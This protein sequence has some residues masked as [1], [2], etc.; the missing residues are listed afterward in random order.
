MS[1]RRDGL[2]RA[3]NTKNDE[4]YTR[5]QDIAAEC[6]HYLDQFQRK[7]IYCN[8]DTTDSNFVRYFMQL[9][10]Q[11]I[12]KDVLWSGG[13]GGL[14][15]RSPSA[16]DLLQTADIVVTNPPFSLFREY[17][18]LL[19]ASGKQ[20]LI[21]GNQN[22][23]SYKDFFPLF[24]AKQVRLGYKA[25]SPMLFDVPEVDPA[26]SYKIVDGRPMASIGVAWF[27]NLPV[28]SKHGVRLHNFYCGNEAL[29]PKYDNYDAINV[30]RVSDIPVDYSGVIGVPISFLAKHDPKQFILLGLDEALTINHDRCTI[31]GKRL[32][33]RIF[34]RKNDMSLANNDNENLTDLAA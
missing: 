32:Y 7:V 14:D 16:L 19:I 10:S 18:S 12:I 26:K 34:I 20:F 4:F 31:N 27:T 33:A 21:L 2:Q 1:G 25:F 13:L 6:D 28:D 3:K 22:A 29:F 23:I 30:D 15:F 9:K 24:V 17:V 8:C 11:G 5:Y